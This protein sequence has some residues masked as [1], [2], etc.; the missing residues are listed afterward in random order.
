[1]ADAKPSGRNDSAR[2]GKVAVLMG[3][4]SA[5]RKISL[6]TGN[7]VCESLLRSG[8]DAH[9]ID[10][11]DSFITRLID[12]RF[13]RAF[14]ALHGRRGEDGVMQGALQT[15]DIPYTGSGVLGSA[16]AM[17]KVRTKWIWQRHGLPTPESVEIRSAEDLGAAGDRLGFPLM[18][19]PV[20]EGSSCGASRVASAAEL[21]AAWEKA[22]RLDARVM[23]ERW[24][25]G[26]EYTASILQ[27]ADLPLIRLETP[28]EF[29][30]YEAKYLAD[31]TRYLCPCGLDEET[32]RELRELAWQAFSLVDASGW[33]RVDLIADR[34][35]AP[36][37]IEVN[38]IPGMT[39]HS[40]VPMAARQAGIDFDELVVRILESSLE[41]KPS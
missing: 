13:A 39:S 16:L 40:L 20:H 27:G 8:I 14:I 38:T 41:R 22:R 15:L 5:E 4:T 23:A 32:E 11:R 29:Y 35:G 24:I 33:G 30:D 28:R 18:M 12:G 1:M 9:P 7:A 37:L 17:D 6:E 3:G 19:K 2:F 26:T 21:E 25:D 31:S 34:S 10:T 36:W